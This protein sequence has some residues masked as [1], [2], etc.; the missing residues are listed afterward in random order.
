MAREGK[1]RVG[2]GKTRVTAS[3]QASKPPGCDAK[4]VRVLQGGLTPAAAVPLAPIILPCFLPAPLQQR[5]KARY[6]PLQLHDEVAA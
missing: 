4:C 1:D 6:E 5:S 2:V 3:Q